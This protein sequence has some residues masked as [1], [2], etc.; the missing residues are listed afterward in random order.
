MSKV[1]YCSECGFKFGLHNMSCSRST[2]KRQPEPSREPPIPDTP[3]D[4][5]HEAEN[6]VQ[7][8]DPDWAEEARKCPFCGGAAS[9]IEWPRCFANGDGYR[10]QCGACA[11]RTTNYHKRDDALKVWNSRPVAPQPLAP[12][13]AEQE[14]RELVGTWFAF[15]YEQ[16]NQ[17]DR[18]VFDYRAEQIAALLRRALASGVTKLMPQQSERGQSRE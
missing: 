14:A 11:V 9:V 17:D 2:P 10:V 6:Y 16:L 15:S 7:P 18:D 8:L 12:D 1:I 5:L 13:W 4:K 3:L